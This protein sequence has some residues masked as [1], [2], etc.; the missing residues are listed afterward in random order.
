MKVV[1]FLLLSSDVTDISAVVTKQS[2][3]SFIFSVGYE[4]SSIDLYTFLPFIFL[5]TEEIFSFHKRMASGNS[6]TEEK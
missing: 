2:G 3:K 5:V 6:S 4:F 1:L